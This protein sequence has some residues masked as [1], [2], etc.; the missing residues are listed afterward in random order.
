MKL[1]DIG[2]QFFAEGEPAP[3]PAPA[4]APEAPAEKTFT[5]SELDSIVGKRLAKAMKGMPEKEELDAFRAWKESQQTERERQEAIVKERD[6]A[7]TDLTAAQA[8]L[9]QLRR[10]KLL[11]GKGVPAEDVDYYAFKIGK[12]VDDKTDFEAAAEQFLKD[13]A[14]REPEPQPGVLRMSTGG[15][16][17]G[18]TP[19]AGSLNDRINNRLRGL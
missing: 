10:E 1:N 12:L 6:A 18:G 13:H 3:A 14:P 7:R 15:P 5:Q 9:E 11:L 16:L 17:G 4:P 8:E 19:Q 2:L